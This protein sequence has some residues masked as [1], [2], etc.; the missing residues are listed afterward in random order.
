MPE[1]GATRPQARLGWALAAAAVF[2]AIASH[3]GPGQPLAT[4]DLRTAQ[5]LQQHTAPAA[6]PWVLL[7]TDAH[8]PT[9]VAAWGLLLCLG[10]A[11]RR[12]G[13]QLATVLLV[14]P[15][16]LLLNLA[17][18]QVFARARPDLDAPLLRLATYS[19]PSG[20]AA[21]ATLFY[22]LLLALW[23]PRMRGPGGRLALASGAAL[24][25][26]LV[27]WTRLYLGVHYLSDVAAGA[28]WASAWLLAWLA[29]ID[30]WWPGVSGISGV[31]GVSGK[32]GR[33]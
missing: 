15:G 16:G 4:L 7:L 12:Q 2:A 29:V 13:R 10:L 32:S 14:L 17:L 25:I 31:S 26:A 28:A 9:A 18:K 27:G 22:G 24:A 19:F 21:A 33:R 6:T 23:L 11:W 8:S 20:H 1:Q 5:W 30:R 3:I